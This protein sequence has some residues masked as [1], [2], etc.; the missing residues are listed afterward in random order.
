MKLLS[1]LIISI[2]CCLIFS[3][4]HAFALDQSTFFSDFKKQITDYVVQNNPEY[5]NLAVSVDIKNENVFNT[6]PKNVVSFQ[7]DL[8]SKR[9]LLGFFILNIK[10]Y[11]N[12]SK[13]ITT[14]SAIIKT[15]GYSY[16]VVAKRLIKYKE[17]ITENDLDLLYNEVNNKPK[18][19]ITKI[20]EVL[21]NEA[22]VM[23]PKGVIINKSMIQK[24]PIVRKSDK[25]TIIYLDNNIQLELSG[26][27]LDDGA[28]GQK[29]RVSTNDTHKTFEGEVI[30]IQKVLVINNN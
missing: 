7:I 13:I 4:N 11:D 30:D 14:R 17:I 8:T 16:F 10:F 26:V 12:K 28:M 15:T 19:A 22:R 21:N 24:I 18:T 5:T 29:I 20:K 1:V 3:H 23:I 9:N 6:L 25:I 2:C 27:A